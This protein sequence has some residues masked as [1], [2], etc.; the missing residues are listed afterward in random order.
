MPS[1]KELGQ[2]LQE[3]ALSGNVRRLEFLI[4]MKADINFGEKIG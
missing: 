2:E 1:K 3:A 4:Q